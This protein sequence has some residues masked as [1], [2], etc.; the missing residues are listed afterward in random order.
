MKVLWFTNSPCSSIKRYKEKTLSGG[1]LTSLENA[2]K[3]EKDINLSIAFISN[4]E[5]DPFI[6]EGTTYYPIFDKTSQIP[7]KKLINRLKPLSQK[8]EKL[9]PSMLYIIQQCQPDIIH[10]HGTEECFGL[11]TEHITTIPIVF[12]I[13]GLI[14]PYREK[15]FSGLSYHDI[16]KYEGWYNKLKMTSIKED[17]QSFVY[18]GEREC[19]YLKKASYI[20]GRTFWDKDITFL[21]N[22]NRKYFIVNE[23]LRDEFYTSQWKKSEFNNELQIVSTLSF[24][25]YKGTETILKAAQLL[26]NYANFN[27]KWHIIGYNS[28]T[29]ILQITEKILNL[30]HQ[31]YNIKLHGR[32]DA[33]QIANILMTSDIYCHVSHIENSPNSVCEAMVMGMPIIA[34]YAGGTSSLLEHEKDG[35]L[36]Q[37]GD[38][39]ILAGAICSL[40][41]D[42]KKAQQYGLSAQAKATSRHAPKNIIKELLHAYKEIVN[43]K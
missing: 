8:E 5:K 4:S 34:S 22:P 38:S 23:I 37:D 40:Q 11:I 41:K 43:L 2:L 39:Y 15:F 14:A 10:I 1:W 20:I 26:T 35:L 29:P 30:N 17:F 21:L 9:L 6:F 42:F 31:N 27:F 7:I 28:N 18:R 25:F 19:K 12:S 13:Q 24:G 32:L 33:Q 3:Y 36:I 16:K